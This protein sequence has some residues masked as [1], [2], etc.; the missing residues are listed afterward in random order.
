MGLVSQ[1]YQTV[2][3]IPK[4]PKRSLESD[5]AW[6]SVPQSRLM[7][8]VGLGHPYFNTFPSTRVA[9]ELP[10]CSVDENLRVLSGIY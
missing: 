8:S 9:I 6:A 3:L 7:S 4:S 5:G 2:Y 1:Y 10:P